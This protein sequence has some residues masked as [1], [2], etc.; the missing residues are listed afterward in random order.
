[1]ALTPGTRLGPYEIAALIGVGGMGEVYKASDTNLKRAVAIKVL[2]AAV[3]PDSER[4]ARFQREAEVLAA[5]NHANIAQIHGL[6]KSAGV[7][8]LVM[9]LVEGPTLAERLAQGAIPVDDAL[10]IAKQIADALEAA[11]AQ[12]I[13]HRDL[14]PANVKVRPDGTVKVLDFGLAKALDPAGTTSASASMSPTI[15]SPAMT[16]AGMI[17]GTAAYMAPEQARGKVVDKRAD[18][19]AFGA[20]LFEMLTGTRAFPGEDVTDTLAAVVRGEPD[21]SLLPR[22]LSPTL[23]VFLKRCLQKDPRQRVGDIHDVRLA[24]DGAFDLAAP[25]PAPPAGLHARKSRLPWIVAAAAIILTAGLA[26][27]A[28]RHLSETSAGTPSL[29]LTV[30]KPAD[31]SVGFLDLSP[32]GQRLV[33]QLYRDGRSALYVRS[34]DS[35]DLRLLAG[36]ESARTPFWSP[37]S[38]FVGFFSEGALKLVP[39]AGGPPRVLCRETG[40]GSGGTWSRDGVILFGS[41]S[42]PLRRV[43]ADGD[44]ATCTAVGKVE[45]TAIA[46]FPVFLPD[47][48]HYLFVGGSS[49]DTSS[50]GVHLAALGDPTP[51]RILADYSSV[52]YAPPAESGQP[53]HLLFLRDR[54]LMAQPF[55]QTG[56]KPVGDPWLV[57]PDATTSFTVPQVAAAVSNTMLVYLSG[58]SLESQLTWV[59]RNGKTIG[60]V[61]PLAIH[62]G[63]NLSPDGTAVL[64]SR[65]SPEGLITR[66]LYDIERRSETRFLGAELSATSTVWVPDGL[67]ALFGMPAAQGTRGVYLK[68][69]R[70][71]GEP[72]LALP[73]PSGSSFVPSDISKDGRLLVFTAIDPKTQA[74]VWTMPWTG[75]PD[76]GRAVRVVGTNAIESQG[77]ASPNGKWLAYTSN[78]TGDPVV[79]I[80]PLSGGANV[81]RVDKGAEPQWSSDGKTLYYRQNLSQYRAGLLASAIQEDGNGTV[82]PSPPEHLFEYAAL[83]YVAQSNVYTYNVHPSGQRFLVNALAHKDEAALTIVTNWQK[84]LGKK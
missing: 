19:W 10:S 3:A 4:L 17:L 45:P 37:D 18:I 56:L 32:D 43:D 61:G 49:T 51:H 72:E 77:K 52:L 81:W 11:H 65:R 69:P 50:R 47:N 57:A 20:V 41:E 48:Q 30:A 73:L 66:W 40:L 62:A 63:V 78:E 24:L 6:D 36:T 75:K 33:L 7:I 27:L 35:S 83:A 82:H 64:T 9:E 16:H 74:D 28:L 68:D 34:L 84:T 12:G 31:A 25:M 53:A 22:S 1:M 26:P 14:K 70:S 13:I 8:A 5:L 23:V 80:R 2:P 39:A 21:W 71:G 44:P 55:D 46:R 54:S 15:T 59:D 67:R 60:T 42:G 58:A 38:R 29:H 76:F 79:Y